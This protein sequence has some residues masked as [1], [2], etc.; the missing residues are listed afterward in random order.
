[1]KSR[2]SQ[3]RVENFDTRFGS[4]LEIVPAASIE[5]DAAKLANKMIAASAIDKI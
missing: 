2:A 5:S 1:M 4:L 3:Q